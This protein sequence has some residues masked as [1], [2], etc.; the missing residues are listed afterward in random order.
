MGQLADFLLSRDCPNLT[1]RVCDIHA[2]TDS[3]DS[4][5]CVLAAKLRALGMLKRLATAQ[6]MYTEVWLFV[7]DTRSV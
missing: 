5:G 3:D 4:E 1:L 6:D 2:N 7:I